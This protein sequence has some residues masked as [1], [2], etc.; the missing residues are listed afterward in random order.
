MHCLF[1]LLSGWSATTN[2]RRGNYVTVDNVTLHFNADSS[3]LSD[4]SE[5]FKGDLSDNTTW[6]LDFSSISKRRFGRNYQEVTSADPEGRNIDMFNPITVSGRSM[7]VFEDYGP[8]IVER[9]MLHCDNPMHHTIA[10]VI[11]EVQMYI[12]RNRPINGCIYIYTCIII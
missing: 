9:F 8:G 12:C 7:T 4:Y 10:Y 11:I 3:N 1:M 2:W 5:I 6:E